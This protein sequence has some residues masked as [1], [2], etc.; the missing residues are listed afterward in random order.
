MSHFRVARNEE[1][2]VRLLTNLMMPS[3]PISNEPCHDQELMSGIQGRDDSSL[4]DFLKRYSRLVFSIGLR[5][6]RDQGEAE[7]LVQEVFWHVFQKSHLYDSSRGSVRTWLLQIAYGKALNRR[8]Y[9]KVRRFYSSSDL[10]QLGDILTDTFAFEDRLFDFA[11]EISPNQ[12]P[13]LATK[14]ADDSGDGSR[15]RLH[16]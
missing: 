13:D 8:S 2:P 10:D 3:F 4:G 16:T 6:L 5:V 7:D 15:R 9:L 12:F 1:V 14:T 11:Q